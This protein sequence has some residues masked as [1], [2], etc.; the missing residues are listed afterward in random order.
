MQLRASCV[1][2]R[3]NLRRD[4]LDLGAQ[5]LLYPVE[6]EA[7]L[8]G[9]KVDAQ[10]EVPEAPRAADAV[11]VGLRV[12]G[13]VE[14]DDDVHGLYV[15]AAR[16]EVR[17]DQAPAGA[18]AEVV[19]DA[20]AVRLVHAGVDEEAGVAQLR[21]LLGQQLHASDRVA[22]DDRLVDLQLREERVQAVHLLPLLHECVEL[23]NALQRE[24]VHEVDLMRL[25]HVLVLELHDRH[26]ECRGVH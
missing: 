15:D 26:G 14:V 18:V 20:V 5:L 9:H 6:V 8:V 24:L 21:D 25:R 17:G 19:E 4:G 13:E 11:Q 7:V 12:L 3:V 22:E 23:R 2:D 10:A 16:E 1:D